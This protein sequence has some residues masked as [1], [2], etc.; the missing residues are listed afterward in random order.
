MTHAPLRIGV[1]AT[2]LGRSLGERIAEQLRPYLGNTEVTQVAIESEARGGWPGATLTRAVLQ[3]DVDLAVQ[4]A[5]EMAPELPSGVVLA[6]VA[7]R[8]TPFDVLIASDEMILDE[9]PEGAS[10]SAHT[11]IRRAQLLRYRDDLRLLDV[12]GSLDERMRLLDSGDV[13][14]IVVSA[15]AVEHLGFQDRVTEIF[16]TEVLLPPPGQGACAVLARSTAKEILRLVKHL[17]HPEARAELAC[18]RAFLRDLNADATHAVG[19]L[20]AIGNGTI[21]L[22]GAVV[23]PTGRKMVRDTEDGKMGEEERIGARLAKRLL[24][25]GARRIVAMAGGER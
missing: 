16:T 12:A 10:L 23:D 20:A 11:P 9:L 17:D 8:V 5:K 13:D 7:E 25:E 6:A 18:E 21:R 24:D 2:R 1:R 19:A 4:N 15:S 14:G 3:G 22:D